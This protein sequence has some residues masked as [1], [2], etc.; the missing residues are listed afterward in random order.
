MGVSFSI[1]V[2]DNHLHVNPVRGLGPRE[3]ARR[4]RKEGGGL[5]VLVSLLTWSL[6]FPPCELSS[7]E[8]LYQLTVESRK[9]MTSEGVHTICMLGIHPAEIQKMIEKNWSIDMIISFVDKCMRIIREY[10]DRQEAHG[11][12]EIGRPHWPVSEREW[13]IH[14]RVLERCLEHAKDMDVPVHLH[15]ER[16]GL[17]TVSSIGRIVSRI[18]NR[19]YSVVLHHVEGSVIEKAWELGLAPSVPVGKRQDFEQAVKS[20][21]VYVVESDFLDDPSRPGAVIPPWSLARKV[22][23]LGD[24]L[25]RKICIENMKMIY[26][27]LVPEHVSV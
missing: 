22:R 23:K 25:V 1:Y 20:R 8:K 6:G 21:P 26:G 17:E 3:V 19:K 2:S 7:F 4:F 10:I 13:E 15:L 16:R 12:G 14:E 18:G 11:I 27:S 24:E 5:C 9:I